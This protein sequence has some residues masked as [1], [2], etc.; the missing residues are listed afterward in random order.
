MSELSEVEASSCSDGIGTVPRSLKIDR[1]SCRGVH[2]GGSSDNP[3]G[4]AQE[5]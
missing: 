4:G 1:G 5:R 2:K 3:G